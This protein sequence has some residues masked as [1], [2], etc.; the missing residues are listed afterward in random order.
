[1]KLTRQRKISIVILTL[2]AIALAGDRLV[3]GPSGLGPPP[4]SAATP[5]TSVGVPRAGGPTKV[6]TVAERLETL[7]ANATATLDGFEAPPDWL[8]PPVVE[9]EAKTK[10][11]TP[12][13]AKLPQLTGVFPRARDGAPEAIINKQRVREGEVVDGWTVV[14]I[15][16]GRAGKA[17]GVQVSRG[18]RREVLT[19]ESA[20]SNPGS[21]ANG[22]K[23]S[24][25]PTGAAAGDS[26]SK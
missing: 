16:D 25:A 15:L 7:R 17:P 22:V 8:P 1:M 10:A 21:S 9:A 4:A 5:P 12:E 3:F 26:G 23:L 18:D 24:V 11:R 14:K 13:N 2:S 19:I 20:L 6:E